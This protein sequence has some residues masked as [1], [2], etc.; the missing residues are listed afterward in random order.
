M[1]YLELIQMKNQELL[2]Q[3]VRI[4]EKATESEAIVKNITK[5]IQSLDL[6]K[7]NLSQSMTALKRFQMLG[8]ID[9]GLG[10]SKAY[11]YSFSVNALSNL[12]QLVKAKKYSEITQTLAVRS[13]SVF[14]L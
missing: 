10:C 1:A 5:D 3:M 6:A 12:E 14:P 2:S 7:K 13:F 8:T 11:Y 9:Y 4:R